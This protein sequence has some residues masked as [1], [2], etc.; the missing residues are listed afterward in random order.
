MKEARKDIGDWIGSRMQVGRMQM[1]GLGE[2]LGKQCKLFFQKVQD[3]SQYRRTSNYHK[4]LCKQFRLLRQLVQA[5]LQ[6]RK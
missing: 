5:V 3:V 2:G 6:H 4:M 1:G